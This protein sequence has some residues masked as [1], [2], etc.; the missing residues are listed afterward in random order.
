M[1]LRGEIQ[2]R[3]NVAAN[4]IPVQSLTCTSVPTGVI[5]LIVGRVVYIYMAHTPVK[6]TT[7]ART[8]KPSARRCAVLNIHKYTSYAYLVPV[9]TGY[10]VRIYTHYTRSLVVV[11]RAL[12]TAITGSDSNQHPRYRQTPIYKP[13]FNKPYLVLTTTNFVTAEIVS[14]QGKILVTVQMKPLVW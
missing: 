3:T 6:Q 9:H 10:W 13:I 11:G 2:I 12:A 4:T 5:L 1:L 14:F 7:Q 8:T